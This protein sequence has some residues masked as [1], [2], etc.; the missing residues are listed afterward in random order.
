MAIEYPPGTPSWVD[1]ASPDLD[2]SSGFYGAL[3]GWSAEEAG[4]P[5]QTG[6]YRLFTLDGAQ[7]AGVAPAREGTPPS[8][9]TYVATADADESVRKVEAAGGKVV[10]APLEI[11]GTGRMAAFQDAAGGAFFA[12]WEPS[13]HRGAQ[14]V[15]GVGALSWNELDTRDPDA[16]QR[17]YGDVFGWEAAPIEMDGQTVYVTWR[18]GGRTIGGMLP[19]G[20]M[21]PPEVPANWL[22]YFGSED[23]DASLRQVEQLGGRML[24]PARQ[25][26]QGRFAVAADPQ[27]AAFAL[28]EGSYD[29]PPGG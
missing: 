23:L 3:F 9:T 28:W 24:V 21:F 14:R 11:P 5:E 1:L 12:V 18:L 25:M 15:N 16:A 13:G 27:G 8:W 2:A 19:M 29:P 26:P 7:V 17:F 10:V 22:A 6:G 4:P 20:E